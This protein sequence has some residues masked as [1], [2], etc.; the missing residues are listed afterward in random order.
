[1]DDHR[2]EYFLGW[3]IVI[4]CAA[5]FGVLV[6]LGGCATTASDIQKVASSRTAAT[7]LDISACVQGALAREQL[8]LLKERREQE[9]ADAIEADRLRSSIGVPSSIS[10]EVDAVMRRDAGTM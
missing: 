10:H 4:L 7:A 5:A 9:A 1:M 2:V 3:T 6:A 8:E